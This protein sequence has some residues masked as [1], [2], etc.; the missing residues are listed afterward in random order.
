MVFRVI[1]SKMSRKWG[2][3][4]GTQWGGS[5]NLGIFVKIPD[6]QLAT[7]VHRCEYGWMNG[8]PLHV[9]YVVAGVVLPEHSQRLGLVDTPQFNL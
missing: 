5:T 4:W 8:G 1:N 3:K 2:T 7:D 9:K 6:I